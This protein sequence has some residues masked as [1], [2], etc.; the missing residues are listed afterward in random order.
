MAE[1]FN[2]SGLGIADGRRP[3]PS[4]ERFLKRLTV[5]SFRELEKSYKKVDMERWQ[6]G[7][8]QRS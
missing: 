2:L 8:M 5:F 4:W 1:R 3:K 7:L 6:S